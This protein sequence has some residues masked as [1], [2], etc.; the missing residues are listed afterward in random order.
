MGGCSSLTGNGSFNATP[1]YT[2][3][4]NYGDD[5]IRLDLSGGTLTVQDSF[6]PLIKQP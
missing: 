3:S 6:T 4:M 1:P 2:N 5:I